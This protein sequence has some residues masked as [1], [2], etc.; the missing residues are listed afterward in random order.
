MNGNYKPWNRRRLIHYSSAYLCGLLGALGCLV[1]AHLFFPPVR[2]ATVDMT[3]LIHGFVKNEAA[4][5]LSAAQHRCR[6]SYSFSN[7]KPL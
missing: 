7:S 5:P 2:L 1:I 6:C 3:G 4:L